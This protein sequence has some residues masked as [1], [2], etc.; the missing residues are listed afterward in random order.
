[1]QDPVNPYE[2]PATLGSD[3]APPATAVNPLLIPA[4]A[5]LI[6]ALPT[7]VVFLITTTIIL[8]RPHG[9]DL[10]PLPF[11]LAGL[12]AQIAVIFGAVKMLRMRGYTAALIAAVIACIPLC[13]PCL[14]FGI[15]F[16]IWAII[17][18][19]DKRVRRRFTE[20]Q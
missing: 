10:T 9:D 18:L 1:M 15:P 16:G 19:R 7:L 8:A 14:I 12:C 6:M 17:E 3:N 13:T 4:V 20:N 2:P 5:L 11:H